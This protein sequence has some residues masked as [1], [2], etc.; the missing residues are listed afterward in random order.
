MTPIPR[1]RREIATERYGASRINLFFM[2]MLTVINVVMFAFGANWIMVSSASIP[3]FAAPL[4]FTVGIV[5]GLREN[6]RDTG[7]S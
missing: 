2:L 5:S 6:S 4:F 7:A 3:Y 1:S